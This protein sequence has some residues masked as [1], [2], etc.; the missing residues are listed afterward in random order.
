MH[1]RIASR[2]SWNQ[3]EVSLPISRKRLKISV[4]LRF[5]AVVTKGILSVFRVLAQI[6]VRECIK[7]VKGSD[8]LYRDTK[9]A[10]S[11]SFS[12]NGNSMYRLHR[13]EITES[14]DISISISKRILRILFRV[15][16]SFISNSGAKGEGERKRGGK[17]DLS[18]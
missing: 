2:S 5:I 1:V 3:V 13:L 17:L 8:F 18:R 11:S 10:S 15:I 9:S 14:P 6:R 4:S 16:G 12:V 7:I